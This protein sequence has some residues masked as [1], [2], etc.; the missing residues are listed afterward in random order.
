MF[1]INKL[2]DENKIKGSQ[3][4]GIVGAPTAKHLAMTLTMTKTIV[5]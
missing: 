1:Y 4:F 3:F 2:Q 5:Q